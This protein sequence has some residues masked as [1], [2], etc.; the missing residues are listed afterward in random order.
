MFYI[1]AA[2]R[3]KEKTFV[4]HAEA[5]NDYSLVKRTRRKNVLKT[6]D[7]VKES[8]GKLLAQNYR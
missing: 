6:K 2:R 8:H 3:L 1:L 7:D 4:S 5:G